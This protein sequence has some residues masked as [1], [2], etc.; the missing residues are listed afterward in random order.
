MKPAALLALFVAL[1]ISAATISLSPSTPK[2]G[3]SVVV[4][5]R[6]NGSTV[7]PQTAQTARLTGQLLQID[8]AVTPAGC[9]QAC[10]PFVMPL[11]YTTQPFTFSEA[12]P[13]TIEYAFTGCD[14]KR[15]VIATK[16]VLVR[17]QCAF[18]R[19]LTVTPPLVAGGLAELKWCDPSY[20]PF[21]DA[22][23]SAKAYRLFLVREGEAPIL[24]YE[25][26]KTDATV[27]LAASDDG[28]TG[29]FVEA[30][31]CDITIAGCRETSKVL[32]SNVLPLTVAANDV[33]SFGGAALCLD[34]RFSVMARFHTDAGSSPAHPVPMTK[35]SGY[36]WFF[37]PQNA[38]VVVKVVDACGFTSNFWFFAAGMT[39]VGVDLVVL[40]TKTGAVRRYSSP[41]GSAFKAIQDTNAFAG[42]Q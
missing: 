13:Y 26:D 10:P 18:D 29:S 23:E 21:P 34:N 5:V 17:P 8:F 11:A 27:R 16:Q 19:S 22:G 4:T 24:V 42:C 2:A 1:P 20:S 31:I 40:D 15:T 36:F 35:E 32:K 38:E 14:G 33:C 7:C 9:I 25:G 30:D 6:D 3:D 39:D 37:G 28:A 41:A 12:K